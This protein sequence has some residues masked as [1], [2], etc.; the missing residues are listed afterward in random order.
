[1]EN[2]K[3]TFLKEKQITAQALKNL[4]LVEDRF[5]NNNVENPIKAKFLAFQ[6]TKRNI[7]YKDL[8]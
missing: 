7:T 8:L 1:M 6:K 3:V 2:N 4:E 5:E